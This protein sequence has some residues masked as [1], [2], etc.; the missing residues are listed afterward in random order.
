LY[1]TVQAL[2]TGLKDSAGLGKSL[3]ALAFLALSLLNFLA[4]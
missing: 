3:A 1:L 2:T 4:G